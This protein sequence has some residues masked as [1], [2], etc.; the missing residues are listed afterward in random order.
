MQNFRSGLKSI[1][2]VI[3]VSSCMLLGGC[4]KDMRM[5][6]FKT[7]ETAEGFW[8]SGKGELRVYLEDGR[9]LAGPYAKMSNARFSIAIPVHVYRG[10]VGIGTIP[11]VGFSRHGNVYALLDD[12]NS[13]LLMEVVADINAWS[14][15][16]H[17]EA[18][19]NDG[20]VF[21]CVF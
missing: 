2:M 1:G 14:G 3:V 5:V 9:I 20:R 6:E 7:G 4:L 18:R 19:T 8:D 16:G 11:R 21:K 15:S 12:E 13:S 17:G 10:H